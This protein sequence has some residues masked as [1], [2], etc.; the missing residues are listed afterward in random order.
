M[1]PNNPQPMEPIAV[2]IPEAI[3]LTGMSRSRLYE[4][5]GSGEIEFV[6]VGAST[7]ILVASLRQFVESR[8]MSRPPQ[9]ELREIP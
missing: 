6:K 9:A 5:M 3:R 7:L 8:R 4:L 2:R 1:H